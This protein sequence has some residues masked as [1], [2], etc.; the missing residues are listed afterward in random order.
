MGYIQCKPE[1]NYASK[2]KLNNLPFVLRQSQ[3]PSITRLIFTFAW[4]I[5]TLLIS[6]RIGRNSVAAVFNTVNHN[7]LLSWLLSKFGTCRTAPQWFRS[8][9]NGISHH[10]KVQGNLSQILNLN[11]SVPQGSCPRPLLFT[12]HASNLFDVNLPTIHSYVDNTQLY[13]SLNSSRKNS[14]QF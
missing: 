10:V 8:Y 3:Q 6:H 7:V 12:T 14:G 2:A 4:T 5:F 13:V 9:L 11:C 1:E